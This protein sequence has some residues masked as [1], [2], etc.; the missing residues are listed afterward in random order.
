E[1]FQTAI[2]Q[3]APPVH[4]W[5]SCAGSGGKSLLL[6]DIDP[7]VNITVSDIRKSILTNLGNRFAEAG[8]R[9]YRSYFMDISQPG[10]KFRDNKFDLVICDAPCTGSGTWSR[11]P[12][13]LHYFDQTKIETYS[14]LQKKISSNIVPY[15]KENGFLV[16]ITCSVFKKENEEV[17]QHIASE[18][19]L[20][21]LDSKMLKGYEKKADTMFISLF[22]K[23]S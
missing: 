7:S 3:C 2:R 13:Q 8:I 9:K 5:D 21:L 19:G 16:Y 1:I 22:R 4:A 20:N 18:T 6:Y 17:T 14:S 23:Q 15:L 11:T 10:M 12:E